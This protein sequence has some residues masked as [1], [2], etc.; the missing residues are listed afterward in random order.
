M[1]GPE[2]TLHAGQHAR[3]EYECTRHLWKQEKTRPPDVAHTL[4]PNTGRLL[5]LTLTGCLPSWKKPRR[6]LQG[7]KPQAD[8]WAHAGCWVTP[9]NCPPFHL[10]KWIA[11]EKKTSSS[12]WVSQADS[13]SFHPACIL[14]QHLISYLCGS[15]TILEEDCWRLTVI[16]V[17]RITWLVYLPPV[18]STHNFHWSWMPNFWISFGPG[19]FPLSRSC[20]DIQFSLNFPEPSGC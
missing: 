12:K 8:S 1:T 3:K 10:H 15:A 17:V 13:W 16:A 9:I 2:I 11:I 7:A 5:A 19:L 20:D 18:K 6:S 4:P 14:V